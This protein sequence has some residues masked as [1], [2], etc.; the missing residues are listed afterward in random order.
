MV[1]A[2]KIS[3]GESIRII[4]EADSHFGQFEKLALKSLVN[5]AAH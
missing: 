2:L 3:K 1:Q 4:K 5:Q